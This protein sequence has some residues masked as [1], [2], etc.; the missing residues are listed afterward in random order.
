[1]DQN[2][3]ALRKA[4]EAMLE[5]QGL[6]AC[7]SVHQLAS[8]ITKA[9][10]FLFPMDRYS[11]RRS[12]SYDETMARQSRVMME[13]VSRYVVRSSN[14]NTGHDQDFDDDGPVVGKAC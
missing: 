7:H 9:D 3:N 13:M 4:V 12:D 1:M 10:R 6:P 11:T 8:L 5:A 14:Y 2:A